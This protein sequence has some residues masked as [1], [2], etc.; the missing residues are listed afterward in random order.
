MELKFFHNTMFWTCFEYL[1]QKMVAQTVHIC[2]V[3][4]IQITSKTLYYE[5][6]QFYNFFYFFMCSKKKAKKKKKRPDFK[7]GRESGQDPA[8]IYIYMRLH[9]QQPVAGSNPSIPLHVGTFDLI[10]P[11]IQ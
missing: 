9:P 10:Y 1:Y 5:K 7:P 3:I 6:I 2:Y 4:R 8:P 11:Q